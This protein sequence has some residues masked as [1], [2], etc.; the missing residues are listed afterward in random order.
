MALAPAHA[1]PGQLLD[2]PV[3]VGAVGIDSTGST[4]GTTGID[5]QR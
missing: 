3:V 1:R 4:D 5:G 2:L